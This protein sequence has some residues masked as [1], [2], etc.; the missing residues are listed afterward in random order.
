MEMLLMAKKKCVGIEVEIARLDERTNSHD[1][2]I[3]E[4]KD[5]HLPHIYKSLNKIENKIAY[6]SGAIAII[7]ILAQIIISKI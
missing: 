4:M 1:D 6:Y 5:N 2:F 7:V 3:K